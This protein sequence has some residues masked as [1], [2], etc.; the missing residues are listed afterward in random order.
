MSKK[1]TSL[2]SL[3]LISFS[4]MAQDIYVSP[5]GD[6]INNDG[7]QL[8]PFATIAK[9]LAEV[10]AGNTVFILGDGTQ[11]VYTYTITPP[12]TID[13]SLTLSGVG[14]AVRITTS[15]NA[16][17]LLTVSASNVTVEGLVLDA[18]GDNGTST[19]NVLR[20]SVPFQGI[21]NINI[22]QNTITNGSVAGI[23]IAGSPTLNDLFIS[24]N[25]INDNAVGIEVDA[26]IGAN[27]R[28]FENDLSGNQTIALRNDSGQPVNASLNWWGAEAYASVTLSKTGNV[29][30]NPW[31]RS[32]ANIDVRPDLDGF[33][34]LYSPLGIKKLNANT[35]V[36]EEA[37]QSV[38]PGGSIF[39]YYTDAADRVYNTLSVSKAFTI[40]GFPNPSFPDTNIPAIRGIVTNGG[41][42]TVKGRIKVLGNPADDNYAIRLNDGNIDA[43]E[44]RVS[45]DMSSLVDYTGGE[46][47]GSLSISPTAVAADEPYIAPA[48]GVVIQSGPEPLGEVSVTRTTGPNG[49]TT[50]GD[51]QQYKSIAVRWA[52]EVENQPSTQG[53]DIRLEW[54]SD[55][56]NG[57]DVSDAFVWRKEN[58][59]TPW[60]LVA[61]NKIGITSTNLRVIDVDNVTQF[62]SWTVSDVNNPLPV[63]L[64]AFNAR[65][66]E[67]HVQ[68]S[69]ETASE[70]NA[71]FFAIE[72]SESGQEF[73]QIG[74]IKAAGNSDV[75]LQY[76]YLDEQVANRFGGTLFYRLRTVDFDGSYEYSD[77]TSVFI[78]D[79]GTPMISAFAR[80]GQ[81]SMKLFTRSIEPGDYHLWVTD[82]SGRK[83]YE[84]EVQLANNEE[85]R[86]NIGNLP[87]SI[88]MIR[89]VG[90]QIVLATKFKVE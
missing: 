80:E 82:L 67:P 1:L 60:E 15:L 7:S 5:T 74:T 6:D 37:A 31:F 57:I 88:Y 77:I 13:K 87:R 46:Y 2:F 43:S 36:L 68:L 29:D 9:A 89:C 32:G 78:N 21:S 64:T 23:T 72:R 58:E 12:L 26:S 45:V 10:G 63:E 79:E 53:R 66:E 11:D 34:S 83:L 30:I 55:Y 44:G 59:S 84:Q 38:A 54:T 62:S 33:Q 39:I 8:S 19:G 50:F 25:F 17:D 51:D 49:I 69:W 16:T 73:T 56:D 61:T 35:N 47:N 70:E 42:L 81:E 22:T 3:L 71:D 28:I 14:Q 65:L 90:K 52:I 76:S 24:N 40:E 86:I 85:H 18:A 41:A 4:L 48:L 75:P 20:V 27:S